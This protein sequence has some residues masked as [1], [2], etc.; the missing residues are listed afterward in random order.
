MK[1][2]EF[3]RDDDGALDEVVIH[4]HAKPESVHFEMMDD[5]Q[6]WGAIYLGDG[7]KRVVLWITAKDNKISYTAEFD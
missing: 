6:L 4:P 2:V 5:D 7:K 1:G 3:R